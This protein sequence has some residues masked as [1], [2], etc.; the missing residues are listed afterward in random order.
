M[1]RFHMHV[2]VKNLDQSIQFY[3][4]LFGQKPTKVKPDYAKWM[5][6]DPRIN[7][8]ISTHAQETGVDL[9]GIQVESSSELEEITTRLKNADLGVFNEG[10]ATCCY[11]K[12]TKAWVSDPTGVAWEAYQ[13]MA[14]AEVYHRP[15]E[16][17]E[18]ESCVP[19]IGESKSCC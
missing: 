8:A 14:E 11:A 5:L 13:T 18:T 1:K 6:D 9:V 12:S 16:E 2:G 3:S 7:F 19:N 15:K 4:T 10:E 17:S